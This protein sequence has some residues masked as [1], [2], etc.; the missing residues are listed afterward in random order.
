MTDLNAFREE[1][2]TWLEENCPEGMRNLSF[3]WEDAH[4]I[5]NTDV[6]EV[7]RE[8]MAAKGWIAPMWP[9][10]YGGGGLSREEAVV[11]SQEM[12]RIKATAASSG[13]GLTMIGPTLLEFGSEAQKQRHLPSICDGTIRWCQG[14][15]EP[16]AGSDLAALQARAVIEGDQFVIN[17]QKIWTS[18]AQHADW[19]F[20]LV[21]TDPNAPKHEGI[22]FVLLDM[23]QDGVSVKPIGLISGSSP[24]CETF[25]DNAIAKRE[26]LVGELN[27]G[28]SI[29]KRLLQFERS[30]IGGLS[31]AANRKKVVKT[32]PIADLAKRYVGTSNGRIADAAYREKILKQSMTEKAF[33]L[34]TARVV[35]ENQSGQT[36]G[37]TTSIF[38]LVGSTLARE[39]AALKS[40]IMG[41]K[42]LGWE[43]EGFDSGEL[44]ATRNWLN[45]RAVTIYGGTNEV[46]M[47]IIGKRV[48]GLPD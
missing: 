13:M 44:E 25:L 16:G 46:Q 42:G 11:L 4:K 43:G 27:K 15:S 39:S 41:I 5:Y 8:R 10:A 7:W 9:V 28:W 14:Y 35:Q 22:S 30:G 47:N 23:H 26:D 34:T 6:A 45:S 48:L 29:G 20:A 3:H 1:T 36:P 37:A 31:G 17:G 12:G 2:R 21:R 19:M 24:F 38:K 33:Q 18:G 40:E 32:N